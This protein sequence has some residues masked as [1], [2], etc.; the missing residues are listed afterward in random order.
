MIYFQFFLEDTAVISFSDVR[1]WKI[2]FSV[3]C[4]LVFYKAPTRICHLISLRNDISQLLF[5]LAV[6]SCFDGWLEISITVARICLICKIKLLE[7]VNSE[8]YND[9]NKNDLTQDNY[10]CCALC[11]TCSINVTLRMCFLCS[12]RQALKFFNNVAILES[13]LSLKMQSSSFLLLIRACLPSIW[14]ANYTT[15]Q[16]YFSQSKGTREGK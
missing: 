12:L 2:T 9:T 10:C 4:V 5:I 14:I 13:L 3:N 8:H 16:R 1:S 11:S 6:L 15:I 7:S